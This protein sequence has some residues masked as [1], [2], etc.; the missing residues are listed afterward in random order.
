MTPH[1]ANHSRETKAYM[2]DNCKVMVT[3]CPELLTPQ[4]R[5]TSIIKLIVYSGAPAE[6]FETFRTTVA[7]AGLAGVNFTDLAGAKWLADL[8]TFLCDGTVLT[9]RMARQ[10]G[11]PGHAAPGRKPPYELT[12]DVDVALLDLVPVDQQKLTD[13]MILVIGSAVAPTPPADIS[14]NMVA[15]THDIYQ[16]TLPNR[17]T[18]GG[19]YVI[20]TVFISLKQWE[21]F[22]SSA[23][24]HMFRHGARSNAPGEI[25]YKQ[26]LYPPLSAGGVGHLVIRTSPRGTSAYLNIGKQVAV[27]APGNC[28]RL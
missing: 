8:E 28:S 21:F 24:V 12:V 19:T 13:F 16:L 1:V 11:V 17:D 7:S 9:A 20:T 6:V 23:G 15:L 22:I 25:D 18:P 2:F 27:R 14:S 4:A 5:K 3:N 10:R 26:T